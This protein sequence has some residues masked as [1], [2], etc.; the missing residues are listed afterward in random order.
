MSY[1]VPRRHAGRAAVAVA[2]YLAGCATAAPGT[3]DPTVVSII[4]GDGTTM[5]IQ[6]GADIRVNHAVTAS[7]DR[8]WDVLPL[9][10]AELGMKP[11]IQDPAR[12]V[13]GASAH[14]FS[15]RVLNRAAS[16]FFDCGLDPGLQRPL[17]DQ[18]PITAR[19]V[20][21]VNAVSR[22]AELR[23]VVEGT[24][25]RTG[26]NAGTATCR[27]T[28]LMEALVGQMVQKKAAPA[29]TTRIPPGP[30]SA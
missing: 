9:V 3:Q 29:D 24:A 4:T 25:R 19:V 14:R 7:P 22:G 18:V 10:Y 15:A 23:T 11:D 8:V 5:Q 26:G 30:P 1:V 27:S 13:L 12:H 20:T 16:D 28:G 21:E 2:L 17:A 6:R